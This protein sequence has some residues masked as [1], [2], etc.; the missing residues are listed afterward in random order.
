V[1]VDEGW[2]IRG[3][4]GDDEPVWELHSRIMRPGEYLTLVGPDDAESLF[5]IVNVETVS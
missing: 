5:R 2:G 3:T 1:A 4:R